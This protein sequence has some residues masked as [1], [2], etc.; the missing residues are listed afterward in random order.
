MEGMMIKDFKVLIKNRMFIFWNI[1]IIIYALITGI[2][3]Q[4][5]LMISRLFTV[6]GAYYFSMMLMWGDDKKGMYL[7]SLPM[8]RSTVITS[9]YLVLIL[10]SV[11]ITLIQELLGNGIRGVLHGAPIRVDS[12]ILNISILILVSVVFESIFISLYVKFGYNGS[13]NTIMICVMALCPAIIKKMFTEVQI[14]GFIQKFNDT[15]SNGYTSGAMFLIVA[16]IVCIISMYISV[17]L[18][19]LKEF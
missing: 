5:I 11:S 8:A 15:F 10:Y 16:T 19:K 12:M 18:Y 6:M 7:N 13:M 1:M 3:N 17:N 9:K 2:F 4:D 14:L